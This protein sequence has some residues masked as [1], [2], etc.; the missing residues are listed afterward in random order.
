MICHIKKSINI[1]D[2]G[3]IFACGAI[4]SQ[5]NVLK[6]FFKFEMIPELHGSIWWPYLNYL[7]V[8]DMTLLLNTGAH[9][10]VI[11]SVRLIL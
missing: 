3:N 8:C 6:T 5:N 9:T 7:D 2:Y 10:I 4:Y 1:S 11:E